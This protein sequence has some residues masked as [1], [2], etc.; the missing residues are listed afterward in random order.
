MAVVDE[1]KAGKKIGY[2]SIPPSEVQ[3]IVF[4]ILAEMFEQKNAAEK[5]QQRPLESANTYSKSITQK[6]SR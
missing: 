4:Y 5:S 3:A 6:G 2:G 1:I